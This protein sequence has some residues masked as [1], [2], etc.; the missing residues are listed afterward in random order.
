VSWGRVRES[1]RCRENCPRRDDT[2]RAAVIAISLLAAGG[3]AGPGPRY[4]PIAPLEVRARPDGGSDRVFDANGDGRS[5]YIERH[6][7]AGRVT[8][9]LYDSQGDGRF[10]DVVELSEVPRD[11]IRDLLVILD[12]VPFDQV[13]LVFRSGRLACFH[14]PARVIAPFPVMT[15][16][17]LSEFFGVSPCPGVEASYYDGRGITNGYWK[18]AYEGN[19]PWLRCTDYRMDPRAHLPTYLWPLPW[20]DHELRAIQNRFL[21]ER[22]PV[23]VTYCVGTSAIG[24]SLGAAGHQAALVRFDR[25]VS[26]LV[27]ETRGRVRITAF[28]DHGHRCGSSR[29]VSLGQELARMGYHLSEELDRPDDAISIEFGLV[30]CAAI[31]TRRPASVAADLLGVEGVDLTAFCDEQDRVV[32]C[33]RAG[34]AR[35]EGLKGQLRYVTDTGDPLRLGE[36]NDSQIADWRSEE[37]WFAATGRH[38]YPDVVHRLWRAFHGLVDHRPDVL[39]SLSDGYHSG[40]TR[41]EELV[42]IVG[43]HGSLTAQGTTG[44]VLTMAGDLPEAIPMDRLRSQLAERGVRLSRPSSQPQPAAHSDGRV[45]DTSGY[46]DSSGLVAAEIWRN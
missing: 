39:I 8:T 10:S 18:Y 45:N 4:F 22:A 13:D 35:I 41:M 28:S 36:L 5:D 14:P 1:C 2:L 34:R 15:D 6:G 37:E 24:A 43:V 46:F 19:T 31:Y 12:S 20:F 44:F 16:L 27:Y 9:L 3:C 7:A 25:L 11:E 32:V 33:G 21:R 38:C 42:H 30:S 29:R 23:L 26:Q 40:S 17:S